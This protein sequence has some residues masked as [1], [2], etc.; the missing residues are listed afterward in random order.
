[1]TPNKGQDFLR[2]GVTGGIGS[3]KSLVCSLFREQGRVVLE[4]DEIARAIMEQDPGVRAAISSTFGPEAYLH[5]GAVNKS[6][7]RTVVFGN[8]TTRKQL[9]AIVHPAV[10]QALDRVINELPPARRNPYIIVEAALVFESGLDTRL[11]YT[12]VVHADLE[13]RIERLMQRGDGARSEIEQRMA[14]Q[15]PAEVI[16]KRS[17]F[18][19]ENNG[20]VED[21][22]PRVG[23][24][25]RL[26][27][28][29]QQPVP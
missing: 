9:N 22:G 6:R 3:G 14:A 13:K 11:D 25:D 16:L 1:M 21:L 27:Q 17:D 23:F 12:I 29:I 15:L 7:L 8:P 26:L 28:T 4:A 20:S 2:V 18:T 19:I 24:L 5:T 10:F